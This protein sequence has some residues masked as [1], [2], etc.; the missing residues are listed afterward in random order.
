MPH[1]IRS[2]AA[3]TVWARGALD[4]EPKKVRS[5][6]RV[7]LPLYD[8]FA[9]GAGLSAIIYG[10]PMLN[11]I[12]GG[13]VVAVTGWG[14]TIVAVACLVGVAFPRL[15]KF[16]I[17]MKS[18]LIGMIVAYIYCILFLPSSAQVASSGGPN[19]FVA[20][21]L[22]FGLPLALFRLNLLADESY[23]RRVA[24]RMAAI[25]DTGEIPA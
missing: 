6:W 13:E 22:A 17:A 3:H 12:F 24:A 7:W 18:L 9:I 16:E 20:C 2:L 10:S 25:L 11:R 8:V 1:S 21:M 4:H 14:F 5:L 19:F 15:W 23:D